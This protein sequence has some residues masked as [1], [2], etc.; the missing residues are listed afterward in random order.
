MNRIAELNNTVV[1]QKQALSDE[2]LFSRKLDLDMQAE[3]RK[4]QMTLEQALAQLKNSQVTK[5][6]CR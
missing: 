1:Q 5:G 6:R 4:M 3:K 2:A